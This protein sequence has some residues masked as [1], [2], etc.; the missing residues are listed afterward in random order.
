MR[1]QWLVKF[2]RYVNSFFIDWMK[3]MAGVQY[4]D[5]E[6]LISAL[7]H[8]FAD[9]QDA[10]FA[11]SFKLASFKMTHKQFVQVMSHEIWKATGYRFT[12][13]YY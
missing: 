4:P 6:Q 9:V 7:R 12:Y 13:V 11:G 10:S 8:C 1:R 5:K 2:V 3:M